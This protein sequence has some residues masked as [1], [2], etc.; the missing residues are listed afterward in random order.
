MSVIR[1]LFCSIARKA[2]CEL[3]NPLSLP[4]APLKVLKSTLDRAALPLGSA[5]GSYSYS[6]NFAAASGS[7]RLYL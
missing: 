1:A 3:L 6:K 4:N 7:L 2:L 5:T